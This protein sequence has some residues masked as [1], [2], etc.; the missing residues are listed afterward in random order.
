MNHPPLDGSTSPDYQQLLGQISATYTHGR[1]QAVQAVNVHITQTYWQVGRH[2]VEFE[3]GGKARAEYGKALINRL[4]ADLG[5]RHG[6]GFSR[7]NL[8]SMRLFYQRYPK[9][10]TLSDFLTWSH[11]VELLKLDDPLERGFYEQQHL[12]HHRAR[13]RGDK[14]MNTLFL[15]AACACWVRARGQFGLKFISARAAGCNGGAVWR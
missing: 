11:W 7:T 9:S 6:K 5:L 3:Q 10:Q 8:I 14:P 12:A 15:I 1:V 4:A 2:I 13:R